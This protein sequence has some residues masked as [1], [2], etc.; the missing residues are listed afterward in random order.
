MSADESKT[1]T[2]IL[3]NLQGGQAGAMD[4]L[5]STVYDHL[6][7]MAAAY[8]GRARG[9]P[10]LQPTALVHELYFKLVDQKR[11]TW[12]NRA[13]FYATAALL[14]RRIIVDHARRHAA[15]KRGGGQLVP[16]DA[17][18][19][20]AADR[21]AEVIRVHE[22][23]EILAATDPRQA[24]VVELRFFGG[25]S[26]EETAGVLGISTATAK[27]DWAMARAWL[28]NELAP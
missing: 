10:T 19:E 26:I 28:H 6:R 25:L 23:L 20:A 22:A 11:M 4:A 5:M 17:A 24:R 1:V 13:H 8:L 9:T 21:P 16:L 12:Q 18:L 15:E 7:R 2:D 14:M 27:R 3:I